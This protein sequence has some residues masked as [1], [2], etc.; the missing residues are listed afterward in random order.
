MPGTQATSETHISC[1]KEVSSSPLP[2]SCAAPKKPELTYV[3]VV[4]PNSPAAANMPEAEVTKRQDA[5]NARKAL[6]RSNPSLY[7]SKTR[8]SIRQLPLFVTDRTLKR[9]AI[10]AIRTFDQEVESSTREPLNR[11]EETDETVSEAIKART[12][13]KKRGERETAVIQSKVVR[14]TEKTDAITGVGKSKGYA[15]LELRTHKDALKVLRYANN[16]PDIGKLMLEW[17]KIELGEML[18]RAKKDLQAKREGKSKSTEAEAAA[19]A[20]SD[21]DDDDAQAKAK[22][23]AAKAADKKDKPE[24]TEEDLEARVRKIESGLQERQ[25]GM[26]GGKT[27]LLEFSIENV[28]VSNSVT[29]FA[30]KTPND[31]GADTIQVVKRRGEKIVAAR[32]GL[33][34]NKRK[35]RDDESQSHGQAAEGRGRGRDG[36]LGESRADKKPKKDHKGGKDR[37][38]R[39]DGKGRDA[40]PE[41]S[42][43]K[44]NDDKSKPKGAGGIAAGGPS[45][46][47]LIGRKRRMK[48][49]K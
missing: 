33:I 49:G 27:L 9:M 42:K 22:A 1:V 12:S 6:L 34:G 29:V 2:V 4:F 38:D 32:D 15:F 41:S 24:M 23:K 25:D 44:D 21:S 11:A 26:R 5:F 47:S 7:I 45:I 20:D 19:A 10:H 48:A 36:E 35:D 43:P 17:Y 16:N 40:K 3:T 30:C 28:Q 46:G 18:E 13:K 8:L 31:V 39:K 14:Q 37:K